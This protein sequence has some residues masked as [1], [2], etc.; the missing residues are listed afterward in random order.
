MVVLWAYAL[1]QM[2]MRN[3]QLLERAEATVLLG[4]T[5]TIVIFFYFCHSI[6]TTILCTDSV[7]IHYH[8]SLAKGILTPQLLEY[9]TLFQQQNQSCQLVMLHLS[10]DWRLLCIC[11]ILVTTWHTQKTR[12]WPWIKYWQLWYHWKYIYLTIKCQSVIMVIINMA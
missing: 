11:I 12:A 7:Y 6:M 1:I 8:I 10:I 3:K 9:A 5:V 4:T 2:I